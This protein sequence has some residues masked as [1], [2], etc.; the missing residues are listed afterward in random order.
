V[1]AGIRM[2]RHWRSTA[3]PPDRTLSDQVVSYLRKAIVLGRY[4][5]G[6]RLVEQQLRAELP[7]S[8]SN[9]REVL[10]RLEGEGLV[11]YVPHRGVRVA[12]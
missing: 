10:W 8:R 5:Q 3:V 6:T 7:V 2:S 11:E 12:R 1:N 4:P 9:L